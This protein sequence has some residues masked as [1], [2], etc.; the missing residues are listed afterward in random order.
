MS[1]TGTATATATAVSTWPHGPHSSTK[2]RGAGRPH[3]RLPAELAAHLREVVRASDPIPMGPPTAAAAEG[4]PAAAAA[5]LPAAAVAP[6]EAPAECTPPT[7][8]YY[9]ATGLPPQLPPRLQ[10]VRPLGPACID[11]DSSQT[12]ARQLWS[13]DLVPVPT[14]KPIL[15]MPRVAPSSSALTA[16]LN[17]Q[18]QAERLSRDLAITP[19]SLPVD[20]AVIAHINAMS[21]S[22]V[23][24]WL[25]HD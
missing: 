9:V 6:A 2:L 12:A 1:T 13:T 19:K 16:A 23:S 24:H 22:I 10:R 18:A 15:T 21:D 5:D 3:P 7:L 20:K 8:N 25:T 17:A 14:L 4:L 11:S